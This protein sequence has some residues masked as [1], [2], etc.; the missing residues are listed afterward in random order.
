MKVILVGYGQM[1]RQV[2]EICKQRN[3]SIAAKVDPFT[4]DCK[5]L[6]AEVAARGDMVIEFSVPQAAV[7]CAEL[8]GRFGINAVVGTTGWYD[9]VE[10]V[11]KTILSAGTGYL[12][13]SNFSIGAH[14]FFRLVARATQLINP[15]P[16][17]DIM[18]YELHHKR[19]KDS[20][21]GTALTIAKSILENSNRKKKIL[22]EKIDRAIQPDELHFASVRGGEIPGTHTVLLDSLADTIEITH[23][24][25]NRGGLALGAVMAAEWLSGKKGFYNVDDFIKEMMG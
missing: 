8:Y 13:G 24:V 7:Q 12:Y 6:T 16:D 23:R 19:K 11:R 2:E 5:S 3:H 22:T 18:G 25:R 10:E 14:I 21:S 15:V 4:G 1:G 9:K 20:P 17:Y